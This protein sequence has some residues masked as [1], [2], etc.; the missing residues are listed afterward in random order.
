MKRKIISGVI[1]I[2]IV[3]S[4]FVV[5]GLGQNRV[6]ISEA[7]DLSEDDLIQLTTTPVYCEFK[8]DALKG[9]RLY[10]YNKDGLQS[11]NVIVSIGDA[12]T[13]DIL[14]N[15]VIPVEELPTEPYES[16]D[17]ISENRFIDFAE[18]YFIEIILDKDEP[19]GIYI[20]SCGEDEELVFQTFHYTIPIALLVWIF[21]TSACVFLYLNYKTKLSLKNNEIIVEAS[22]NRVIFGIYLLFILSVSC[23]MI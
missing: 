5:R 2:Y 10:I 17:I 11:G 7:V 22:Y 8:E 1:I 21:Y 12:Y 18:Y 9:L 4:I 15:E 13:E 16:I 14:L 19:E 20:Y 3:L 6:V 23:W